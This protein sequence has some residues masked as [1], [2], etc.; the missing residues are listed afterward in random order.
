MTDFNP[1]EIDQDNGNWHHII[2]A[3][4]LSTSDPY[5]KFHLY[6]DGVSRRDAIEDVIGTI[7]PTTI[8]YSAAPVGLFGY[9]PVY[10]SPIDGMISELYFAPGQYLDLSN[11]ANLAKFYNAG[12]AVD[13][14]STG[15]IPTGTAPAVYLGGNYSQ[16]MS[17]RGTGGAI[18]LLRNNPSVNAGAYDVDTTL[19]YKTINGVY[20][21][22]PPAIALPRPRDPFPGTPTSLRTPGVS[23]T[24]ISSSEITASTEDTT[25]VTTIIERVP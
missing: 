18:T 25:A 22:G 13:L 2:F 1:H 6:V 11:P 17:N 19:T 21:Y 24:S 4:D 9:F 3:W 23:G 12:Y 7:P 8:D 20:V 5:T 10:Q 16:F 14:G 15:S